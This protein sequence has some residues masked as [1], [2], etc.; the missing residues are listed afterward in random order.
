M[1]RWSETRRRLS[2]MATLARDGWNAHIGLKIYKG[3]DAYK[4][5]GYK[6]VF[7]VIELKRKE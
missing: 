3:L 2:R 5:F 1:S 6:S 7:A 4:K